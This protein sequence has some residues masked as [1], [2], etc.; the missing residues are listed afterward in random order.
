MLSGFNTNFRYRGVL[1]HVQTEDSGLDKPR[2]MSHLFKGGDILASLKADYSDRLDAIDLENEV[3]TL[4][5]GQHKRMLRSLIRGEHDAVICERMGPDIFKSENSSDTD[6]TI[7]PPEFIEPE[8][9]A[10]SAAG[11]AG[12][13][14]SRDG[15]RDGASPGAN[16][17]AT[18]DATASQASA[19]SRAQAQTKVESPK[20]RIAR[21]FGERVES[22]KP[23]DEV[24]L[25]YLVDSARKRKRPS[26]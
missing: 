14:G 25:D 11:G 17:G 24:V 5:E 23:L 19:K 4:M 2:V 12:G 13:G 9:S 7:P 16:G 15:A 8:P 18:A 22:Q 3:R 26:T 1:F 6:A 21:T 10:G 20:E